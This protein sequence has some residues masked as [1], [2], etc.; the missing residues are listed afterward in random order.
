VGRAYEVSYNRPFNT[1]GVAGGQ[2]WL[3]SAEYPMVRWLEANGYDVSYFT[4]VDTDRLGSEL[5]DHR[6]FL[7][8]GHDEYWSAIQ[9]ANVEAA[10]NAGVHLAFFSG[11]EVFW[12]T[13]WATS[14]DGSATP[15]RT[16]ISYKETQANAKIDPTPEW[17]GTWRDPRFSP[18]ADGGR[19]ENALTGTLFMVNGTRNDA[20]TV[21]EVE[22]KRRFWRNTSIATLAPGAVATLPTGTLGYEWDEDVDNGFRPAGLIRLSSTTINVTPLY[23]LDYGS[24]YGSGVATHSLTF[25]RHSSG[26]FVFGA[27]T[28]QWSWGLDATHDFPGTP[29]DVR[30][31]QATVNLFADMGVQPQSLGP[32][33]TAATA[34]SD[35]T[36]PSSTITSPLP[37]A[38]VQNGVPVTITGTA[39]EGG[40]GV[41]AAVEVSVDGGTSWRRATGRESWQYVW[42][43]SG[44]GG[45]LGS[46]TLVSR[47][48]DDSGNIGGASSSV[49]VTVQ[50]IGGLVAA[51]S[52]NEG[53]GSSVTD[54]SGSANHGTI[55]GA[56]W[57]ASGRYG[58]ALSFDGVNDWVTVND[59]NSLDLTNGMT[60]EA[61]VRPTTL[62]G[63]RTAIMKEASTGLTYGLYA[64]DNMPWPATYVHTTID[65][66]ASGT[67][68]ITLNEW[69]HL[70]AAYDGATLRLHVNGVE[71][72][73]RAVSGN[74]TAS[75][76]PLRIGGNAPWGEYFQGMIDD[77]RVYR[78]A[79]S[80]SEINADM[81][82]PVTPPA[83]DTT[84]PSVSLTTPAAGST[85]SGPVTVSATA[86]DNVAVAGVQFLLDG[87]PLGGE[88]TAAPYSISWN[89]TTASNGSHTLSA[90]ARDIAGNT[91]L[92]AN[93]SVTVSNV[94]DTSPP[95][96]S[97]TSPAAGS[98]LLGV[99]TVS[100]N[101]SDDVGVLGVQ[102]LLDS[103]PLGAEDTAGPYS[104]SWDTRTTAN[105]PHTVQAR[106]RDA[107]G[108]QTTSSP[109]S[110]TVSNPAVPPGLV[111]ALAFD[112]G[113]GTTTDDASG[114]G[115]IG[116]ISGATWNAAGRSGAALSFDGI[117]DWVTIA[118]SNS[119]DLTTGMTLEAWVN[120]RSLSSWNT[121]ML[122]ETSVGLAYALYAS[123]GT[124]RPAVHV[125][126]GGTERFAPG[127]AAVPLNTWTHLAATYDGAT[128]RLFVNAVQAGSLS[129]AGSMATS[130]SPLRIGGNAIWGEYFDGL[131]DE[132]RVYTRA[133]SQTELQTDMNAPIGLPRLVITAPTA[134]A[135]I[136]STTIAVSYTTAGNLAGVNHAH[137]TLD[138][139]PEVSDSTFDGAYQFL[140][141][142][143]GSHLLT[144][145]LARADHSKIA[146]SDASVAFS[147]TAPDTTPPT[148]GITSPTGG[149][150][151]SATITVTAAAS[152][153]VGMVGVQF[154]LDGA[155]LGAEDT[156]VPYSVSWDTTAAT[157]GSHTLTARARDVGTNTT[158]SSGVGV[159]VSNTAAGLVAAFGFNEGTG[160]TTADRSGTG[161][162]GTISGVAWAAGGKY[163]QALSFDGVNDWVTVN[164]ANSLDLT[165]GMTLDAWVNPSALSGW[166]TAIMKETPGGQAYTL[167]AHDGA[168][169]PAVTVNVGGDQSA[170]G[171]AQLPLNVWTH[172]AA[173][174][175]GTTLRLYVNAIQVGSR[176]LPGSMA[177]SSG[178]LRIGGNSVWGEYFSGLIDEVRIYN[179]ALTPAQIQSDMNTP[180]N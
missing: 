141:V 114:N 147:T 174:Y 110:V 138:S 180:I 5:L 157:N 92:A 31:Q 94:T 58:S 22:G 14:I 56:T 140:N 133:L 93:V 46:A 19:P 15:Y 27:G 171:T 76:L 163:G 52:F 71:V 60:L 164:D 55:L 37:G 162:T 39:A 77:V 81:N 168:P 88:D 111:A 155:P 177:V 68:P 118:D 32:A 123:E 74:I 121:T 64:H 49:A 107:S 6:L 26:A 23:L 124:P 85:L 38:T 109:V 12:K 156:T 104:I 29:V 21:P 134:G 17:T 95:T 50:P 135:I 153:N 101:A 57:N 13:R 67:S 47:A 59:S 148:V 131:I 125:I 127:T 154:L 170:V 62:S 86:S 53:G 34:S 96:V 149:A 54:T 1:R 137:F 72:A 18:P 82:T 166:R 11:N 89:T 103:A 91:T 2:S 175:D 79:L 142:P 90:R 84:P 146:G 80:P 115:N 83:P 61:W 28:V 112:E 152:D 144:G 30:M 130:S 143:V 129:L 139:N 117:N 10:R 97:I 122:K 70:A 7:S 100:A 42:T 40:G 20:I 98:T 173:T 66:S 145:Y 4:G 8:V 51:Y 63:W 165:N 48:I 179:R 151:V 132:V 126:V 169:H 113:L 106:A 3:F 128:L 150:T 172:L 24:T 69:T 25:Y 159:T 16:L 9:R 136:A 43:P 35:L 167:Y 158:T 44:P 120:P 73:S 87:A 176:A 105:G 178:V 36:P 108:K 41:V 78:R 99:V 116:T 119:L 160:T 102:F 75:S 45:Q 33:L 65:W 161:N